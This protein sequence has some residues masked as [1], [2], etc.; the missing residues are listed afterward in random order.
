MDSR[1]H[2][3]PCQHKKNKLKTQE[4]LIKKFPYRLPHLT[5]PIPAFTQSW[6]AKSNSLKDKLPLQKNLVPTRSIPIPGLG[7]PRVTRQPSFNSPSPHPP[8]CNL[9]ELK[10]LELRFP[11]QDLPKLPPLQAAA[12]Q[13][14]SSGTSKPSESLP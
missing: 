5:E 2:K 10:L 7:A 1:G 8:L 9:W 12:D 13:P 14:P 4:R 3:K 11:T 6:K